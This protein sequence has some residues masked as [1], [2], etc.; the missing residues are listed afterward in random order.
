MTDSTLRDR[1]DAHHELETEL[2]GLRL[3]RDLGDPEFSPDSEN[4]VL[5]EMEAL[6]YR[7]TPEERRVLE[8]ERQARR[9]F[10]ARLPLRTRD[11]PALELDEDARMRRCLPPRIA[12]R[13]A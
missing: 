8:A 3:L 2:Y 9:A 11:L 6:W 13:A 7:L 12:P 10:D 1:I 5:N 4:A